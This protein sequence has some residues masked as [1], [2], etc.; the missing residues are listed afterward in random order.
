MLIS[1]DIFVLTVKVPEFKEVTFMVD[2]G[3]LQQANVS[4][5][6]LGKGLTSFL[7]A[8]PGMPLGSGTQY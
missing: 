6:F 5:D 1:R 3:P 4:G 8:T 7:G 2:S